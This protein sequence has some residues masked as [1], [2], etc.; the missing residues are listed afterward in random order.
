MH[1]YGLLENKILFIR[2]DDDDEFPAVLNGLVAMKM[3]AKFKKPTVV[4]RLN[5]EGFIR[6]SMRNVANCPLSSLFSSRRQWLT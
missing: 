6:G 5:K 2:L 4:A 3:A 1:K